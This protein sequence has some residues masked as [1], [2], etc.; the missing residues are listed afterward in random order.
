M[1]DTA[2]KVRIDSICNGIMR[3]DYDE[4]IK[5]IQDSIEQRNISRRDKLNKMVE[6]I[7]GEG[8][9]VVPGDAERSFLPPTP[10]S[11]AR[12]NPRTDLYNRPPE[13][14]DGPPGPSD[15]DPREDSPDIES[16]SPQISAF[17]QP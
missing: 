16:R 12:P 11:G 1:S 14:S 13:S 4:E 2:R 8:Y 7:Y 9:V 17:P 6:E 10:V 3:G 15:D 5:R